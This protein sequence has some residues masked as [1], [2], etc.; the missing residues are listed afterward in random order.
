[1]S[2][3]VFI[4]EDDVEIRESLGELLQAHGFETLTAADGLEAIALLRVAVRP[5]DVIILEFHMPVVD[6]AGFRVTQLG[7]PSLKGI[8][9][10]VLTAHS[11]LAHVRAVTGS[12]V[13]LQKPFRTKMLVERLNALLRAK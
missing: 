3:L 13:V 12:A 6:G 1:M 4:I 7:N 11:D 2:A 5:P 8:P 9:V 10:L